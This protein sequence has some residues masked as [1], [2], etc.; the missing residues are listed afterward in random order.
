MKSIDF[1]KANG[2][3]DNVAALHAWLDRTVRYVTNGRHTITMSRTV[4]R[5]SVSQNRLM[6]MWFG[7]I[8]QETGQTP[9]DIHDYYCYKYLPREVVNPS[10]GE[11][12]IVGGHTSLLSAEQFT[13]FLNNVQADAASE[14]G[15]ILPVP[16]DEGYCDFE[17]EYKDY[18]R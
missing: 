16:G 5:R 1:T 3:I 18:A 14:L 11:T 7:C 12:I 10:T 2:R 9:Q 4:R 6:W 8:A 17:D 13:N 15:I